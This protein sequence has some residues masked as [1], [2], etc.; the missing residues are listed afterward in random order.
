MRSDSISV[1]I[2]VNVAKYLL[3]TY[4]NKSLTSAVAPVLFNSGT[5]ICDAPLL[6]E[7]P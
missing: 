5:V 4:S 7:G 2:I 6:P 1:E 3:S